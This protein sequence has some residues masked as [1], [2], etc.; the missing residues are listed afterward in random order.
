MKTACVIFLTLVWLASWTGITLGLA[1]CLT[2]SAP[3]DTAAPALLA[4]DR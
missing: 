3:A 4:V 1:G 2:L